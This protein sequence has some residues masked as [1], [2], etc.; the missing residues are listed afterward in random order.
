MQ[1]PKPVPISRSSSPM[2]AFA[3]TPSLTNPKSA[4]SESAGQKRHVKAKTEK[5]L[6]KADATAK[7]QWIAECSDFEDLFIVEPLGIEDMEFRYHDPFPDNWVDETVED[8]IFRGSKKNDVY[9]QRLFELEKVEEET[10][11]YERK[12]EKENSIGNNTQLKQLNRKNQR[13]VGIQTGLPTSRAISAKITSNSLLR[14]KP[15]VKVRRSYSAGKMSSSGSVHSGDDS[16]EVIQTLRN[17]GYQLGQSF[18]P[19]SLFPETREVATQFDD[20]TAQKHGMFK[21]RSLSP[22]AQNGDRCYARSQCC[23]TCKTR[24]SSSQRHACTKNNTTTLHSLRAQ[25]QLKATECYD[26]IELARTLE[27]PCKDQLKTKLKLSTDKQVPKG[28][29]PGKSCS[30]QRRISLTADNMAVKGTSPSN[31]SRPLTGRCKS[32]KRTIKR[33]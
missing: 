24:T 9:M 12:K 32:A 10:I 19:G 21:I 26:I 2:I 17:S 4:S 25:Y 3:R 6:S 30:S 23:Q 1:S 27:P 16:K 5:E 14:S 33:R 13:Q 8:V 28:M 31:V 11:L 7:V 29:V 22:V 20:Q 15:A 18:V